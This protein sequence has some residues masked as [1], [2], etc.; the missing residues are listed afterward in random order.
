MNAQ[1]RNIKRFLGDDNIDL[2]ETE[3]QIMSAHGF[4]Q[5][6]DSGTSLWEWKKS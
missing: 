2:S 3:V 5:V 6:Y 1:K 4:V